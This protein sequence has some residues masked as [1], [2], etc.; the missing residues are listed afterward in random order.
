MSKDTIRIEDDLT[1]SYLTYA[2]SVLTGRALPDIRD[3]L[4][5]SPLY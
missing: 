2:M 5:D 1:Q 4:I 3:G